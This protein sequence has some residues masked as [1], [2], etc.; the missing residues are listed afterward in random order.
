MTDVPLPSLL[1]AKHA[2]LTLVL[3]IPGPRGPDHVG[4]AVP[5]LAAAVRFFTAVMGCEA[6]CRVGPSYPRS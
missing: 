1:T 5:I 6:F 4:H 2:P 3:G